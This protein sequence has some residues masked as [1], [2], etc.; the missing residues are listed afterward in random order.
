MMMVIGRSFHLWCCYRSIC[1]PCW[2]RFE[3]YQK[4]VSS[5]K[6]S[7]RSHLILLI[8]DYCTHSRV[9]YDC[10]CSFCLTAASFDTRRMR[11]WIKSTTDN[12]NSQMK[13]S[14]IVTELWHSSNI[15]WPEREIKESNI[16][17]KIR[18]LLL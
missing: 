16:W 4:K 9:P 8:I 1:V 6:K 5:I 12:N 2:Y 7:E 10:I 18:F 11:N 17:F 13:G 14:V 15:N 3:L